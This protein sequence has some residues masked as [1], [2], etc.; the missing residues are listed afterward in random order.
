[1]ADSQV[2]A[3]QT[4]V[5]SKLSA[6]FPALIE[7]YAVQKAPHALLLTG[8]VGVGKATLAVLLSQALL[9][10]NA[11]KP[12]GKCPGCLKAR[13]RSHTN[14]LV[15]K[16]AENQ[17]SVKVEQARALLASL[18]TYPFST[19]PRVVLLEQVDSFTPQAQNALLKALEE[20]DSATY[21]LLTCVNLRAVLTTIRSRCQTLYIPPWPDEMVSLL[22]MDQEIP[23]DE[24]AQL[25]GF[26][27]GSP[28]KALQIRNDP[29][30]WSVKT[31]ADESILALEN[32]SQL[33]SFSRKLRDVKDKADMLLDYLEDAA[34]RQIKRNA[35]Q[36]KYG[37]QARSMLEGV[38]AARR[39]QASNLSWQAIVDCLLLKI[40]EDNRECPM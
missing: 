9:C 7:Q 18:S 19:G 23:A 37:K 13:S 21:F 32:I 17:R 33:P 38:L 5:F 8:Q 30:F 26:S 1:M 6:V 34:L 12:C 20:P 16:A 25:S 36:N 24:A 31:L 11:E 4:A 15:V 2:T 29:A 22:L 14:L 10:E 27:G 3:Q 35:Q 40:L 39:H 28:G